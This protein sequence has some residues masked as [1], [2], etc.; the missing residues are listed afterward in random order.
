[1]DL[2]KVKEMLRRLLA[3]AKDDASSESEIEQAT[4]I[5]NHYMAA[6]HLS[7]SDVEE[8]KP[9][10]P[11]QLA[12][13]FTYTSD[14]VQTKGVKICSWENYLAG[15]IVDMFKSLGCYISSDHK[16]LSEN[17]FVEV[18][19]K[20]QNPLRCSRV[21]FYGVDEEIAAAREIYS[22]FQITIAAM[23]LLKHGT[24]VSSAGR[25][26]GEGFVAGARQA[27]ETAKAK[28]QQ[29]DVET[30]TLIRKSNEIAIAKKYQASK[31]L[32]RQGVELGEAIQHNVKSNASA[33]SQGYSDGRQS[34]V[35]PHKPSPKI[36]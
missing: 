9:L 12:E 17:G 25:A 5:A 23:A 3:V 28:E 2:T 8:K 4:S 36:G 6:Y 21:V 32:K 29:A 18:D 13:T 14:Y 35:G 27:F 22:N 20:T 10:N 15:L 7:E 30:R 11:M 34:N 31:W 16:R 19:K 24:I 33:Y 1:M 26:Y